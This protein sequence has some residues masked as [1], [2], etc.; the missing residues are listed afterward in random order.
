MAF[1]GALESVFQGI[2]EVSKGP[3]FHFT[4]IEPEGIPDTFEVL[5]DPEVGFVRVIRK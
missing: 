5:L 4:N 1:G 2:G 3:N